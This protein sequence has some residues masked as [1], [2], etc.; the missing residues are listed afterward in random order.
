MRD[1]RMPLTVWAVHGDPTEDRV[2]LNAIS[3]VTGEKFGFIL[4]RLL[5]DEARRLGLAAAASASESQ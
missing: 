5:R 2:L 1:T 3:G 4:R